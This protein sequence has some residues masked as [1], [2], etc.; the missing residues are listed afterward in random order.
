MDSSGNSI[1]ELLKEYSTT[2]DVGIRNRIVSENLFLAQSLSRKFMGRGVEYEDLFQV[3]SLALIKA[4]ERY[5]LKFDTKFITFATP[6]II[7]E[8]KKYFRDVAPVVKLPRRIQELNIKISAVKKELQTKSGKIPTA[9]DIAEHLGV[10]VETVLE[11]MEVNYNTVTSSMD[12][13]TA[14]DED[15][16]MHETIG[17]EDINYTVM[18]NEDLIRH[19]FS[20]LDDFEKGLIKMRFFE[21]MTQSQIADRLNVS[22]MYISRLER[23][24]ITKIRK[25]A[26]L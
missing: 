13:G 9:E 20:R 2:R 23:S 19:I 25:I 8:I 16:D 22:Q 18:E 3:A 11:S 5:D 26:G 21:E 17:A 6:T 10:P 1:E 4:V 15:A 12:A 7:G 24:I 14:S